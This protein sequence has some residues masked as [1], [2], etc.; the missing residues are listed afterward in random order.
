MKT[1]SSVSVQWI[2]EKRRFV[3]FSTVAA[4]QLALSNHLVPVF[5]DATEITEDMVQ[6]FALMKLKGGLSQK[7]IKDILVVAKMVMRYANRKQLM[8]YNEW[9]VVLPANAPVSRLPVLDIA[10]QKRLMHYLLEHMNSRNLGI[11]ICLST[12][13]RIGEL[14][15]LKWSNIDLENGS[16]HVEQTLCRVYDIEKRRSILML[17]TPKTRTSMREI[18]MTRDVQTVLKAFLRFANSNFYVL[19]NDE[20]PIE[21][22]TYRKY[23]ERLLE[24]LGIPKM[25][26]HGL[27]HSFATRCIE[28]RCDYKT[29]SVILGHNSLSTTMDL[30]VHPNMEQKKRCINKMSRALGVM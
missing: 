28:S 10:H 15:A 12:G 2:E 25:R 14:C 23:Y 6:A 17:G 26:F 11:F 21:P 22:R 29:V 18:P 9:K 20:K 27:R 7:S 3:K 16:I 24:R 4:Y 30:Y 13:M 8:P 19:T 1:F 5:G